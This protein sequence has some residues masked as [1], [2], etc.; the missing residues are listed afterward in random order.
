ML[1]IQENHIKY[2]DKHRLIVKSLEC[3]F[4]MPVAEKKETAILKCDFKS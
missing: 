1:S 4:S 2:K 3:D